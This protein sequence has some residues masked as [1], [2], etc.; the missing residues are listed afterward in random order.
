LKMAL[1]KK[2]FNNSLVHEMTPPLV[3]FFIY[4]PNHSL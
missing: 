3:G 2:D 4:Y 1:Q